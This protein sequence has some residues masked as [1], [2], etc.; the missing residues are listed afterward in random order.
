MW[1]NSLMTVDYLSVP[2][3]APNK[4]NAMKLI[5]WMMDAKLQAAYARE[6]GIGPS[7]AKAMDGLTQAE[8]E[9]LASYHYQKGEMG[10]PGQQ[11]LVGRQQRAGDRGWKQ[12]EAE[13][14]L[15]PAKARAAQ[16][17]YRDKPRTTRG[18]LSTTAGVRRPGC[19][20]GLQHVQ[21]VGEVGDHLHVVL[22]Q[23]MLRPSSCLMR[24]MS[25]PGPRA[26]P[27]SGRP[28]ARRASGAGLERPAR[29][30][31][32]RVSERPKGSAPTAA[33]RCRSSSVKAMMSSTAARWR[34][35]WRR[36]IRGV[37][38]GTAGRDA[39]PARVRAEEIRHRAA[40]EDII[41]FTELERH[42]HA[43]VGA[44]PFGV[45]KLVGSRARWRSS[46]SS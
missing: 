3:G 15:A 26:R 46:P 11:R 21:A 14:A 27:G 30:R 38:T 29:A 2:R 4:K 24:R 10:G 42:R 7:N 20:A 39:V 41:A 22:D 37:R 16:Q 44:L 43:A 45:Q 33:W 23:M 31:N 8:R 12:V 18:S 25:A 1:K 32:P 5:S 19:W 34:I 6:M 9:T 17:L 13:I 40:V 35:C 36:A 28:T